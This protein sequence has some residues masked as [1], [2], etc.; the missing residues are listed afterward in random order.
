MRN[1]CHESRMVIVL[2]MLMC[3]GCHA[4]ERAANESALAGVPVV[5][6]PIKP[7]RSYSKD[8]DARY[9]REAEI[10]VDLATEILNRNPPRLAES[11]ERRMAL[12]VLD[13]SFHEVDAPK[14]PA[15]QEF[16]HARI[17]KAAEEISTLRVDRGARIWKLYNHGF[18]VRTSKVTLAFDLSRT[19]S[20]GAAGFAV[21][22]DVMTRIIDQ[23][24]VLFVSHPHYDHI[25]EWVTGQFLQPGKPVVA[26]TGLWANKESNAKITHLRREADTRQTLAIQ[27]G[28][29][30]LDVVVYPGHQGEEANNMV[31]VY[32]PDGLCFCHTGDQANAN[33]FQWIDHIS[34]HHRVDVLMPN[35]WTPDIVRMVKGINPAV[36]IPGHDNELGH[37]VD[38]RQAYWQTY[39]R[40]VDCTRPVIIMT[41]G[42]SYLYDRSLMK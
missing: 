32:T 2:L 22:D 12:F 40:T 24:D 42:E 30:T 34:E 39:D 36:V 8:P 20:V 9:N 21:A 10:S 23:C 37:I 41:W 18:V 16:H 38:Q 13:G 4:P 14:R 25:D 33:D 28:R 31:L 7:Q 15:I 5:R 11:A 19:G 35:C 26:T 17:A 3:V 29:A 27:S 1:H 6:R